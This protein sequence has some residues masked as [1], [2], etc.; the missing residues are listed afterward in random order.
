MRSHQ[1]SLV[2]LAMKLEVINTSQMD[3]HLSSKEAL[4]ITGPNGCGK[5]TLLR[6]ICGLKELEEGEIKY[7]GQNFKDHRAEFLAHC[8]YIGHQNAIKGQLTIQENIDMMLAL[9]TPSKN[10]NVLNYFG[11]EKIKH[12]RCD[13]LSAGQK[14]KVALSKLLLTEAKLWLL[15]EP[16][17]ALDVDS[18]QKTL[19]LM[20][21]HVIEG[22]VLIYTS[23]QTVVLPQVMQK[24]LK[25]EIAH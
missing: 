13:Q 17:T 18:C 14:R 5:T 2:T 1:Q 20:T 19:E 16:F 10:A 8:L 25:L 24:T 6:T 12:K 3:F 9:A 11:L 15:D 4:L 22:G 21:Q 23:H 7:N